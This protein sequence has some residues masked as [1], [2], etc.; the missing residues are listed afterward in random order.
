M[1]FDAT[2]S[3]DIAI[4]T[5]WQEARGE[6]DDGVVAVGHVLM[7][8]MRDG[9]WGHTLA[10]VCLW[11]DQFSG[12]RSSD[13]NFGPACQLD[14][15]GAEYQRC[16]TLLD[17]ASGEPDTTLG[18]CFYYADTMKTPP[19]WAA[20]MTETVHIGHHRFFKDRK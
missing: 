10:E 14:P 16:K 1:A 17:H 3:D 19:S 6:P 4:R 9:R 5:L 11:R 18:A 8:R 15:A 12:W 13:P 7:N 2:F 20:S